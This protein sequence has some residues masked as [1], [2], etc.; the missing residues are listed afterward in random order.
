MVDIDSDR[1]KGG[2]ATLQ[3]VLYISI[4]KYHVKVFQVLCEERGVEC[5]GGGV[6]GQFSV[7]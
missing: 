2:K 4:L 3:N 7:I 5:G 1:K 6:Q